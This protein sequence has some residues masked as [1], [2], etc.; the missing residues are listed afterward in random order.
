[1]PTFE[2]LDWGIA[3]DIFQK[4]DGACRKV[5]VDFY[6][7]GAQA[8]NFNLMN[9]KILPMRATKD[10]DFAVLVP[11]MDDYEKLMS[12]L[13]Q[14]G[15]KRTN[16]PYRLVYLKNDCIVDLLPFG[17]V[18]K[19][20]K[21]SFSASFQLSV[22]G[23]REIKEWANEHTI[24]GTTYSISPTEGLFLLK[25]LSF[26]ERPERT[27]DLDDIMAILSRYFDLNFDRYFES[28]PEMID[29]LSVKNFDLEAGAC[30]LGKDLKEILVHSP[31]LLQIVSEIFENELSDQPGKIGKYSVEKNY[32]DTWEGFKRVFSLVH[33]HMK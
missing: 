10:F 19:N 33:Q 17:A 25:L 20:G 15:F 14:E 24:Q 18:E 16:E 3:E 26:D 13:V 29:D 23:L 8:V 7:I 6:L 30:M 2:E 27:K 5:G 32:F 28:P 12:L 9:S 1:M 22:V 11:H 4:V 21:V 31:A